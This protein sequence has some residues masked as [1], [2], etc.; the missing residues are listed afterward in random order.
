VKEL[1]H[2]ALLDCLTS[3]RCISLDIGKQ[4]LKE[5]HFKQKYELAIYYGLGWPNGDGF[6][7]RNKYFKGVA[8]SSKIVSVINP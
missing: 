3:T 1:S 2:L 8:S 6:E 7:I 5:V 4:Y